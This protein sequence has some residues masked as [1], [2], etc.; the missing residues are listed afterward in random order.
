MFAYKVSDKGCKELQC[1]ALKDY[2]CVGE[3]CK[4]W[5]SSDEWVLSN[6]GYGHIRVEQKVQKK[7]TKEKTVKRHGSRKAV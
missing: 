1:A 6:D 3:N 7:H 2:Y 4:F 5:K